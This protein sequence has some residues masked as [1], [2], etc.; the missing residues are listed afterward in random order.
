MLQGVAP[1]VPGQTAKEAREHQNSYRTLGSKL[2]CLVSEISW[3]RAKLDPAFAGF[4]FEFQVPADV[5]W[6][7]LKNSSGAANEREKVTMLAK[8]LK[9][10]KALRQAR[11]QSVEHFLLAFNNLSKT[12]SHYGGDP[13]LETLKLHF[14][15]GLTNPAFD[16]RTKAAY[17]GSMHGQTLVE[18]M[19][20]FLLMERNMAALTEGSTSSSTTDDVERAAAQGAAQGVNKKPRF[21]PCSICTD[22]KRAQHHSTADHIPGTREQVVEVL[23]LRREEREAA[24]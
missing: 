18:C 20:H 5:V 1:V 6:A 14:V 8:A 3:E 15:H 10:L 9:D 23:R 13:D 4:Q 21:E 7:A 24:R 22:R 2:K 17:I 11:G 19:T 12:C 16:D